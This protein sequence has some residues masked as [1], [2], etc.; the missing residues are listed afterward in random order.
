[1]QPELLPSLQRAARQLC[2]YCEETLRVTELPHD[3]AQLI[4]HLQRH[5]P[6][7]IGN[8]RRALGYRRSTL[9][10][11]LDRLSARGCLRRRPNPQDRRSFLI[12]L[13]PR[14]RAEG[15]RIGAAMAK[16]ERGIT[17]RVSA[18]DLKGLATVIGAVDEVTGVSLDSQ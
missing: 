15:K 18:G 11:M 9:T 6:C 13:T 17:R 1:M 14:G 2:L 4:C 7:S 8:L 5:S 10:S 16:L 3:E 12:S